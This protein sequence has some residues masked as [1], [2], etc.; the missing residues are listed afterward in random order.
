M[1]AKVKDILKEAK[2]NGYAV[3]AF[4]TSNLEVTQAIIQAAAKKQSPLIIQAT[5]SALEY[6][7]DSVIVDL[8]KSVIKKYSDDVP[9]GFHLDHGKSMDSV[10]KAIELGINSVMIDASL[11]NFEENVDIT[12][13]VTEYA[14]ARGADVQAEIGRVPYLGKDDPDPDWEKIM[15]NPEEAKKLVEETG[16]DALAVAIGNAHGFFRERPEADWNR[17]QKIHDLLP[18]TPLILHGA[19]DWT[20]HK[21]MEAVKR[22]V[23]CFNI[24]TDIRVAFN[25][26]ICQL[27]HEMC[28]VTD[29]RRLLGEARDAVQ[30]AVEEK[31]DMFKRKV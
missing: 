21:A 15:T 17:L 12:K 26:A 16:V 7:G 22:G 11:S 1:L 13:R 4:N 29:P 5:E 14:H 20:N 8:V 27:T 6:G 24:D 30:K 9:I 2:E 25:T 18:D 10:V 28:D 31:I 23:T 19:S 3:G